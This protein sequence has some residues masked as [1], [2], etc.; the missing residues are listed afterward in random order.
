MIFD[1]TL[2]LFQVLYNQP[3]TKIYHVSIVGL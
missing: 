2:F 3:K 1:D